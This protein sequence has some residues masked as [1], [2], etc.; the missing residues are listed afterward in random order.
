MLRFYYV[1][2]ISFPFII[3]YIT[4][5]VYYY[6][7]DEQYDEEQC[8]DLAQ[9]LIERFKKNARIR[10][11]SYGQQQL[12]K[13]GGYIMYSNH[14]GKYDAL[15]IISVHEKPCSVIMDSER[16]KMPLVDQFMDLI[17]GVRLDRNDIK[18]Q[19]EASLEIAQGAEKGRRYIYFPEGKYER[20]GNK[21]QDFRAG[22]FRCAKQAKVP[23]VPVAIYDSH[24]VFDFNS[25]RKVTTQVYFLDPIYFEEYAQKTTKEISIMVKERIEEKLQ[26]LEER[27]RKL[28]L[29]KSFKKI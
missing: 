16:S 6:R 4:K 7:H 5:A 17:R 3:Y 25:L 11:I 19:Y 12:P 24:L 15:G 28:G 1:I 18:Q 9:K 10:T 8:Y 23:I 14:Q 26:Y 2:F 27:R 20:N 13:E 21:L 29:N 22:S